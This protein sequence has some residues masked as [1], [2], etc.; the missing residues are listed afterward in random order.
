MPKVRKQPKHRGGPPRPA[1][2]KA[3]EAPEASGERPL[4]RGQR[5]RRAHLEGLFRRSEL[6][7]E[8][9][10]QDR[11]RAGGGLGDLSGLAGAAEEALT[12]GADSGP[13]PQSQGR[14]LSRKAHAA[15][16]ERELA[17]Y[18]QVLKVQ[19]FQKDPLGALEQHLKNSLKKQ[20]EQLGALGTGKK[21]GR[22]VRPSSGKRPAPKAPAAKGVIKSSLKRRA[23]GRR[24]R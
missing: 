22:D 23:A 13:R 11:Q 1:P 19:A 2:G 18:Q 4:S 20:R 5:K 24:G 9:Q 6:V 17:Q 10:R 7:A 3:E 14:P 16:C 21:R 8:A 15:A 12:D